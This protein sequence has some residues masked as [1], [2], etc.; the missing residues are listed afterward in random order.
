MKSIVRNLLVTGAVVASTFAFAQADKVVMG[1][2]IPAATHGWAGGVVYWANRTQA[3]LEKQY[4]GI[5][6]VVKT[7]RLRRRTGQSGPGLADRQQDQY[8]RHPA[9]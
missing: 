1:V 4:P 3:E 7:R 9:V 6:V 8:A 5:K 2:S